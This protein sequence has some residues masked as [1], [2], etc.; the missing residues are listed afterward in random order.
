MF[1]IGE[2]SKITGLSVKTLRFYHE[3]GLLVPSCVDDESGYRYYDESK[4]ETAR[5]IA[6]LRN[7]D[8]SIKEIREIL[9]AA[10]ND[11]DLLDV[12][13]RHRALLDQR[14]KKYRPIVKSLDDYI[15]L[16]QA[17]REQS[18]TS[19]LQVVEKTLEPMLIAG[20]RM[21]GKYC[22]C[23]RGFAQIGRHFGRHICGPCF[24]LH[25]DCEYHDEGANFEV[26]MPIRKGESTAE[27]SVRELPGGR[28]LSLVHHGR[29][30]Q[31]GPSYAKLIE[32]VKRAGCQIVMPTREIYLKGPGMIFR[33]NPERYVTEIQ[34]LVEPVRSDAGQQTPDRALQ[35]AP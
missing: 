9:A 11:D 10:E 13:L 22:D 33:G 2:F 35:P 26:C 18:I 12:L 29:Y 19:T 7:L 14:I 15:R 4:F 8:L 5:V 32:R 20:V 30:E 31:M 16:E 3:E 27:I 24:L 28:C 21:Q 6:L 17:A 25:Y 23:G 34:M 1:T